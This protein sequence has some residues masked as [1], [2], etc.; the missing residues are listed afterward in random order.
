MQYDG[1][2]AKT[3]EEKANLFA[4]YFES[5]YCKHDEDETLD[6]CILNRNDVE[7]SSFII[8]DCH[9]K[10]VLSQMDINK[11]SGFDGVASI[12]L[13]ECAEQLKSPLTCIF[14]TSLTKM[15]YPTAFKIG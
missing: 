5:V 11:G 4:D 1:I 15:H 10:T 8:T 7:C 14:S 3:D 13:R 12:F 6:S 2:T 9:V